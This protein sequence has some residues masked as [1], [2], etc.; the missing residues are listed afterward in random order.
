MRKY[1]DIKSILVPK[2]ISLT[3]LGKS[4]DVEITID[5]EEQDRLSISLEII[6]LIAQSKNIRDWQGFGIA[7][8]AYGKRSLGTINW[9]EELLNKRA[10]M[11]LRLVKG[12]YWDYE[13]KHAQVSGYENYSV[14]TKK[15]LTDLSYLSCAKRIFEVNSIYPKFATHNAHTI[16]AINY[17][18]GEKIMSFRD[19]MGWENYYINALK[20]F[21]LSTKLLLFMHQLVNIKTF[22][23]IW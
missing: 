17:L 4:K 13:I 3:E 7:L 19:Y 18:G 15:S 8:Q 9:L 14:F 16:S 11:H 10:S 5:A 2:L 6:K 1:E 20:M 23:L 12:A 21:Y 22:Y